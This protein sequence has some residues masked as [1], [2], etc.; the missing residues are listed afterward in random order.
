MLLRAWLHDGATANSNSAMPSIRTERA[1]PSTKS[2]R[3]KPPRA[4]MPP[5]G[6]RPHVALDS[7][8]N[9]LLN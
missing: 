8:L 6:F 5:P 9:T 1:M 3:V 7:S 2:R 4:D